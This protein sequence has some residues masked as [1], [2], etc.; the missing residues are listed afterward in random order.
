MGYKERLG[1]G[2]HSAI[3]SHKLL[4]VRMGGEA[5]HI[6][7]FSADADGLTHNLHFFRTINNLS[8]Q[9]ALSL[10]A[11]ENYA[12]FLA[13][14]I[15]L[16]MVQN[17]ACVGHAAGGQDNLGAGGIING[18]GFLSRSGKAQVM[19]S[20]Q[21]A[22]LHFI[23][24]SRLF[25]VFLRIGKGNG[26]GTVSHGAVHIDGHLGNFAFGDKLLEII[27]QNLGTTY[28]EGRND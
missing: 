12:A 17:T 3:P 16:Q 11:G 1:T 21:A 6:V 13:P 14:Q 24:R 10:E 27:E 23:Q 28:G 18:H 22:P 9:G 5:L 8:A 26:G 7:N 2:G 19:H 4:L 25:V 15:V 20:N